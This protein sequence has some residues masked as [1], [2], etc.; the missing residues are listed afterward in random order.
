MKFLKQKLNYIKFTSFLFIIC[1]L[2]HC[3]FFARECKLE[4]IVTYKT[5]GT[6]KE[7]FCLYFTSAQKLSGRKTLVLNEY[8]YLAKNTKLW[9]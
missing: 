5:I 6:N 9:V 8:A 7:K 3:L 1:Y 4:K 2:N